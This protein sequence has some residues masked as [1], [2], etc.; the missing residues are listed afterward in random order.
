MIDSMAV[1]QWLIN[2]WLD[3][4]YPA[5]GWPTR[6]L[7]VIQYQPGYSTGQLADTLW[8]CDSSQSNT[9]PFQYTNAYVKPKHKFNSK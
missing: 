8:F 9:F 3:Y 5:W 2:Q 1:Y 4:N 6:G 7:I